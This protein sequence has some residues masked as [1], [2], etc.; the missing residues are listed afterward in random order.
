MLQSLEKWQSFPEVIQKRH[1]NTRFDLYNMLAIVHAAREN[2][3]K[4]LEY[5]KQAEEIF[6]KE[7]QSKNLTQADLP[8]PDKE[9]DPTG[10]ITMHNLLLGNLDTVELDKGLTQ[11]YFYYAQVYSRME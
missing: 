3:E 4:S 8:F 10:I 9:V 1:I 2:N 11:T 7:Y 5:L 6:T